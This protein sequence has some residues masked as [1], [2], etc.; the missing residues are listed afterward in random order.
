MYQ[1][2]HPHGLTKRAKEH[3]DVL[4]LNLNDGLAIEL[5]SFYTVRGGIVVVH[6]VWI[7]GQYQG[8]LPGR[9][10]YSESPISTPIETEA[11]TERR[12]YFSH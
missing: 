4:N 2:E 8:G 10:I 5:A 7:R 1:I 12:N 6:R 9:T 11:V 3:G